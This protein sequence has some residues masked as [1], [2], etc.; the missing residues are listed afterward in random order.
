M[1]KAEPSLI[2]ET[3]PRLLS[4]HFEKGIRLVL[5]KVLGGNGSNIVIR[6]RPLGGCDRVP[7]SFVI[8]ALC[9]SAWA[10]GVRSQALV[11]AA[12]EL[13]NDWAA[14]LFLERI[15][16]NLRLAPLLYCGQKELGLIVLEDLS[17][18]D[19]PNT[20]SA[21]RAWDPD[22][23]EEKL[24]EH[25][26]LLGRLHALTMGR[27]QEYTEIRNTLGAKP[28]PRPLFT[29][30]QQVKAWMNAFADISEEYKHLPALGAAARAIAQGLRTIWPS[31]VSTL[32][33]YPAFRGS[34]V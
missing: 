29:L 22:Q 16:S 2:V 12:A 7:A 20:A 6:C 34:R 24:V 32:P 33:H 23:A 13:M 27:R 3:A 15:S 18:G 30:R 25:V 5:D 14:S 10:D 11:N 28:P 19:A 4:D 31:G 26:S 8:K 21:L 9:E 1:R 17:D